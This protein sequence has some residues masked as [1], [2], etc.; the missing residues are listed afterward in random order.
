LS[1]SPP[2]MIVA[3]L[4]LVAALLSEALVDHAL[5]DGAARLLRPPVHASVHAGGPVGAAG[6]GVNSWR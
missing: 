2:L 4:A 6:G 3:V 1:A 5:A